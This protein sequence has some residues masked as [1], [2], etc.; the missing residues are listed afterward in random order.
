MSK[1]NGDDIDVRRGD[2]IV[3]LPERLD[4]IAAQLARLEKLMV[5][6]LIVLLVHFVAPNLDLFQT[7]LDALG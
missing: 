3:P 4:Q 7:I 5:L 1:V 6:V 2:L